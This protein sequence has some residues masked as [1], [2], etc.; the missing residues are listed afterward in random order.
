M[1]THPFLKTSWVYVYK[2]EEIMGRGFHQILGLSEI[3]PF[4]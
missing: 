1:K 4:Y 3:L 2:E